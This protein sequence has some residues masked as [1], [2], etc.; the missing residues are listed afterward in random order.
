MLTHDLFAVANLACI[1]CFSICHVG[2]S[3][4]VELADSANSHM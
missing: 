4:G 1:D 2:M 3:T